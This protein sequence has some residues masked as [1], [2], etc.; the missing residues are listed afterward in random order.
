MNSTPPPE[1]SRSVGSGLP[2]VVWGGGYFSTMGV[3]NG[4]QQESKLQSQSQSEQSD[5]AFGGAFSPHR[6]EIL[7]PNAIPKGFMDGKQA[8]ILMVSIFSSR[9]TSLCLLVALVSCL[10]HSLEF[11]ESC[12]N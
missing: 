6:Y 9:L 8:C 7:A 10:K 12:M 11:I 2:P 5:G 1:Q 3:G 4:T